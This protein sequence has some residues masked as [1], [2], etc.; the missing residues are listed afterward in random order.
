M[1]E[2]FN[3]LNG[4]CVIITHVEYGETFVCR[5]SIERLPNGQKCDNYDGKPGNSVGVEHTKQDESKVE[6]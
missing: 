6:E 4:T 1:L 2:L 3:S 5:L